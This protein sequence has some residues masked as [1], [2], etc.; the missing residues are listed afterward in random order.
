VNVSNKKNTIIP[1]YKFGIYFLEF[2]FF[3]H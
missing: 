2:L 1:F 3:E